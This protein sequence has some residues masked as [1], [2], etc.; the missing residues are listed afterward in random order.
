M[1]FKASLSIHFIMLRRI[2]AG[3]SSKDHP[4]NL[5]K[6]T[7]QPIQH[8]PYYCRQRTTVWLPPWCLAPNQHT[9]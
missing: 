8:R 6:V 9:T 4:Q 7:G 1:T 3:S 5:P 2:G